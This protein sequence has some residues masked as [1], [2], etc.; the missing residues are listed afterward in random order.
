MQGPQAEQPHA[1]TGATGQAADPQA[2]GNQ[3][4]ASQATQS[5]AIGNDATIA[6]LQAQVAQLR[7][8]LD[9]SRRFAALGELASTTTHEFNNVLTTILNYAKM[10]IRHTDEATRT[11]ALEKILSAGQ[12]AE[13][14]TNGVLGIAR[15][16]SHDPAPTDLVALVSESLVLLEREMQKHR[17][18]IETQLEPSGKAW[19]VAGQI[20]QVL[21]NL[22][23]NA[24]QAMPSGGRVGIRVA[25]DAATGTVDLIVQD[26]GEGISPELLPRIFDSGFSTKTG[27]DA[28]GKGGAGL[29]LAACKEIV[30]SHGGKIRVQSAV[31]R[32]T[33]FT[34][35]LPKAKTTPTAVATPTLGVPAATKVAI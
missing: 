19:A 30:E 31:G 13:K 21:L 32:G 35:K 12:R 8:D 34:L 2:T 7:R 18:Q 9:E 16:R 17:V 6:T 3:T 10:G 20:Q 25:E 23:T 33:A 14:I 15:N 11:R 4:S 28:S 27:P 24:R 1:S 26:T 5:Q 22:L 29:G